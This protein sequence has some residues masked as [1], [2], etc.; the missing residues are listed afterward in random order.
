MVP[1]NAEA[2]GCDCIGHVTVGGALSIVCSGL[3]FKT[4]TVSVSFLRPEASEDVSPE[5]RQ[6]Q[7]NQT[8]PLV[9]HEKLYLFTDRCLQ[10]RVACFVQKNI[11]E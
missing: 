4:A 11:W 1:T 9:H 3:S 10:L 2:I 5:S 8:Q 6:T 7:I